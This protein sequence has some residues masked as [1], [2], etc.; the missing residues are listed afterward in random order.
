MSVRRVVLSVCGVFA[1]FGVMLLFLIAIGC[2][3]QMPTVAVFQP[4]SD[5]S[6][7]PEYM[8]SIP[9][10][11]ITLPASVK[12]TPLVLEEIVSYDG[13]YMEDVSFVEVTDVAAALLHNNGD[14]W[15]QT[16]EVTVSIGEQRLVF[17][18]QELPPG[19]SALVLEQNKQNCKRRQFT[20][21]SGICNYFSG[22][23]NV[24]ITA[25]ITDNNVL[26]LTNHTLSDIEEIHIYYKTVY[27]DGLFYMGGKAYF[28]VVP[29][30]AAGKTVYLQPAY[31]AGEQSRILRIEYKKSSIGKTNGGF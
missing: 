29:K 27:A 12:D 15:I 26:M 19:Q 23:M 10:A 22:T 17:F 28:L 4:T 1:S 30:L 24:N 20:D 2:N 16:A 18:V 5:V 3:W 21:V 25:E 7:K 14:Q 9:P 13:A 11:D 6:V 8:S 31:L